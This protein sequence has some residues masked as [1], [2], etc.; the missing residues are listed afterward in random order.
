MGGKIVVKLL[1]LQSLDAI[2]DHSTPLS[3]LID[4]AEP[5]GSFATVGQGHAVVINSMRALQPQ[6]SSDDRPT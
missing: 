6:L 4:Q 5:S 3:A 2:D 1:L